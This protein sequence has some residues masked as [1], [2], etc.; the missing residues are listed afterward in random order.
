VSPLS[1]ILIDHRRKIHQMVLIPQSFKRKLREA[2]GPRLQ[3][4]AYATGAMQGTTRL[5]RGDERGAVILM[6]HS[7]AGDDTR[8]WVDPRNHVPA[9]VF[10]QQMAFLAKH[11]PVV[12]LSQMINMLQRGEAPA[13]GTVAITFDDG[14][15][16]TLTIAAPVLKRYG[17]PATL[18]LPTGYIDRAEA[19]W[20]DQVYTMVERRSANRI[21]WNDNRGEHRFDLD[22]PED[23]LQAYR[24]ICTSLLTASAEERRTM[25]NRLKDGCRPMEQP[26]KLTMSWDDVRTLVSEYP[27]FEIGG[28]TTEHLDLTQTSMEQAR[29]ELHNC[30][31]RIQEQIRRVPRHFSFPYGRT[32]PTLRKMAADAGFESACDGDGG[33]AVVHSTTD[34]YALPR[35][36]A[37]AS[38]RRFDVLTSTANTGFWRR[39]GR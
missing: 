25:L 22:S 9:A 39:L 29:S 8:R 23:R 12:P 31:H 30:M 1:A 19:Q 11:R 17:L 5:Q 21:T 35:V 34:P 2:C 16:D 10:E 13:P 4:V 15:L 33:D 36:K 20:I 7:V 18:F 3:S 6:Y 27:G 32:S 26:P 14:Y 24:I 28:H 38:M 37:P